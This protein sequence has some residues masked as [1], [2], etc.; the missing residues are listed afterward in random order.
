MAGKQPTAPST[1]GS[2]LIAVW[3]SMEALTTVGNG[4]FDR[5]TKITRPA[6]NNRYNLIMENGELTLPEKI[7]NPNGPGDHHVRRES[8][9]LSTPVYLSV[10]LQVATPKPDV[11]G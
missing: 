11:I 5:Y 1:K 3:W 6:Q 7:R 2:G 10:W 9:H 4:I 8:K